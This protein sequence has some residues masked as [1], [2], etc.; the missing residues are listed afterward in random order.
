MVS[1]INTLARSAMP[2][3]QA[4]VAA[5]TTAP[6][7]GPAPA[8][9]PAPKVMAP[10][11]VEIQ[12]DAHEVR[13]NLQEAVHM[14]NE[15]MAVSKRGLGFSVD[16]SLETPIVT[17]RSASTGEVIRQIP[18]ETVIKV[19]HNLDKMKGLLFNDQV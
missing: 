12:Y 1:E 8:A 16:N 7:G 19:A 11:P 13:K 9:A 5:R 6:T 17:V 2:A 14:L 10:K 15:Q 18:N 4:G 3:A